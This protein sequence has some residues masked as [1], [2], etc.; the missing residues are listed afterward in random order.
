MMWRKENSY[1]CW[2]SD[3]NP[4]VVRPV[5]SHFTGW[6]RNYRNIKAVKQNIFINIRL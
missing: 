6:T 4:W 1:P 5:A 3:Y 2:D